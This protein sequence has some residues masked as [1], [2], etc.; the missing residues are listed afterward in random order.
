MPTRLN[1]ISSDCRTNTCDREIR[2]Y[3]SGDITDFDLP[4]FIQ[5]PGAGQTV[6]LV[7]G[8]NDFDNAPDGRYEV[9]APSTVVI[10]ILAPNLSVGRVDLAES[11]NEGD[12]VRFQIIPFDELD[13]SATLDAFPGIMTATI[14][15]TFANGATSADYQFGGAAV[16]PVAESNPLFDLYRVRINPFL[17]NSELFQVSVVADTIPEPQLS[18]ANVESIAIHLLRPAADSDGYG[19]TNEAL[20]ALPLALANLPAAANFVAADSDVQADG[21]R[22]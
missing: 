7:I 8:I 20:A 1:G 13:G 12:I 10:S 9:A 5:K 15:I 18:S 17:A 19:V 6:T 3:A 11:S 22:G 14:S 2:R 21:G 16:T 4:V